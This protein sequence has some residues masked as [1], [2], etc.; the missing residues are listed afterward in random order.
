MTEDPNPRQRPDTQGANAGS[1]H[2]P[3][4][5]KVNTISKARQGA[6][7]LKLKIENLIRNGKFYDS[8]A[9]EE[10]TRILALQDAGT[11]HGLYVFTI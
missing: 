5:S 8:E 9:L 6:K 4:T 2:N 1:L 10:H 11:D 7:A 3:W